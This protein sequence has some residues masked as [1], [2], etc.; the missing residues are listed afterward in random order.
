MQTVFRYPHVKWFYGHSEHTYYLN[1]F[2]IQELAFF[3]GIQWPSYIINLV[4]NIKLPCYTL[5][6]MQHHSFF[7]KL[8][9]LSITCKLHCGDWIEIPGKSC[10][11]IKILYLYQELILQCVIML[12]CFC[13]RWNSSHNHKMVDIEGL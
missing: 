5:S 7:R 10:C 6:L 3:Q 2:I 8:P 12:I 11:S 4:D 13:N 1:Y 9:Y